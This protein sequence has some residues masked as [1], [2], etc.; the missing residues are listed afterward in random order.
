M[1]TRDS[2]R[3][4]ASIAIGDV[5]ARIWSKAFVR[6]APIGSG[7]RNWKVAPKQS[8]ATTVT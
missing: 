6:C 3:R 1:Q 4:A 2:E 8:P 7:Q 5:H